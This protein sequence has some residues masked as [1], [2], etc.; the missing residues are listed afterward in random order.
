MVFQ[1]GFLN[2]AQKDD[3]V[4]SSSASVVAKPPK[5]G[6]ATTDSGQQVDASR[7]YSMV[8]NIGVGHLFAGEVLIDTRHRVYRHLVAEP[9]GYFSLP[10]CFRVDKQRAI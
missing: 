10:Y 2:L 4:D 3:S 5:G 8:A 7:M 6:F 9:I 1:G